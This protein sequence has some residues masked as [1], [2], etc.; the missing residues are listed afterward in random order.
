MK[1]LAFAFDPEGES[2]YL[3]HNCYGDCVVYTGTHDTPTFVQWLQEGDPRQT[4]YARDYLRLRPEEGLGWGV[5]AGAWRT[6][7]RL[8]VA[9]MQDV[10]GLGGDA[11]MNTPGT[12]GD[13]NWTWR[14][15]EQALNDEVAGRLKHLNRIYRR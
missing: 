5:I 15:R 13:H 4:A 11:R 8:A 1:V 14:V 6:A 10:L 9:P 2:A 3:P 12:M 7:A